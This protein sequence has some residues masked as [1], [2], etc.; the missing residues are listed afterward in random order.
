V[1]VTVELTYDM[2]KELGVQSFELE[3]VRTVADVL[4]AARERFGEKAST[5]CCR[6]TGVA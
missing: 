3:D 5:A 2:S 6:A 1:A 4:S